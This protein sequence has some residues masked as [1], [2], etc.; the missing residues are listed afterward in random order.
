MAF[1]ERG[2]AA[3]GFLQTE[4]IPFISSYQH[5]PVVQGYFKHVYEERQR[6]L[7][8]D[9]RLL[10]RVGTVFPNMS[11]LSRQPRSIAVWHPRSA[12][13]TEAWRWFLVD[14]DAP[15]EV[16]D[17]LR[18][19]YMRYSGPGG[20]TEQDD[21]E[22]WNYA[23]AASKGVVA[24]RYPYNYQM[25]LGY[26]GAD[27]DLPGVVSEGYSEQNQRALYQRWADMMAGH[28][29]DTQVAQRPAAS[30]RTNGRG[31]QNGH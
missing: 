30:R 2:H 23:S 16:K 6:R 21:M 15:P 26:E 5:H 18:H 10:G 3:L 8:K 17:F 4:D 27:A 24:R 12:L 14:Q 19:Y 20:L 28:A 31:H 7:G 9:A 22:N 29:W 25:G 1:P 11:F 13:K